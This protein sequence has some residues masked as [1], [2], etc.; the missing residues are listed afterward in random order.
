MEECPGV[1]LFGDQLTSIWFPSDVLPKL[2]R[3]KRDLSIGIRIIVAPSHSS[4]SSFTR[5]SSVFNVPLKHSTYPFKDMRVDCSNR[6]E[7]YQ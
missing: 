5:L 7:T 6:S 4:Y 1:W 3:I 2:V